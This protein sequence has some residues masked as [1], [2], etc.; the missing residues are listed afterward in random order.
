MVVCRPP[1]LLSWF[2]AELNLCIGCEDEQ[3]SNWKLKKPHNVEKRVDFST[4]IWYKISIAFC[5]PFSTE[6]NSAFCTVKDYQTN[7]STVKQYGM[8]RGDV[9]DN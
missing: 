6:S 9:F 7:S 2:L 1:H 8:K 3:R 4:V 5:P